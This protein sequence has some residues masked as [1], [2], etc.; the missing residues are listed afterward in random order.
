MLEN[1]CEIITSDD[2]M[3]EQNGILIFRRDNHWD[4]DVMACRDYQKKEQAVYCKRDACWLLPTTPRE[5]FD[6]SDEEIRGMLEE[7]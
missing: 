4:Y 7:K 5:F 1:E 3:W 2:V 6:L